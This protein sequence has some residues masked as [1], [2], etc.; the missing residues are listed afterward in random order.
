IS[1]ELLSEAQTVLN[2]YGVDVNTMVSD[3]LKKIVTEGY[4]T[5][6]EKPAENEAE[7]KVE[8]DDKKKAIYEK[9]G[10]KPMPSWYESKEILPRDEVRGILKGLVWMADDFDAP[11]DDLD[12]YEE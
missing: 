10:I 1:N 6:K 9:Y 3:Y 11:L 7:P 12:D 4:E 5:S 8:I 2:S